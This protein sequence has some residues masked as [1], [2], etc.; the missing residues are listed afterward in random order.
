[1]ED[2]KK[3]CLKQDAQGCLNLGRA[4]VKGIETEQDY[5]LAKDYLDI[6]CDLGN[7]QACAELKDIDQNHDDSGNPEDK[8]NNSTDSGSHIVESNKIKKYVLD[9]IKYGSAQL[10][11]PM[12]EMPGGMATGADAEKVAEYVSGGMRGE[13]PAVFFACAACHGDDGRGIG[14]TSADLLNLKGVEF[15]AKEDDKVIRYKKACDRGD[16][17]AYW[18]AG[19]FYEYK[20]GKKVKWNYIKAA[21]YYKK[22]CDLGYS[23]SCLT[24]GVLYGEAFDF[25]IE[26]NDIKAAEY[27]S[28]SCDFGDSLGCF[29]LGNYYE[30]GKGLERSSRKAMEYYMKACDLGDGASCYLLGLIYLV[31]DMVKL[32]QRKAKSYFK[33]ACDRGFSEGCE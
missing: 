2:Y 8:Q 18:Q 16:G 4:Y 17:D 30:K 19:Y 1:M 12:G 26:H 5:E 14:G 10:N 28:K 24:L 31:G 9:V 25:A 33:K 3:A 6:A 15:G 21:E 29:C 23:E 11:Y 20:S 27:Y 22:G 32:N 13:K 7:T